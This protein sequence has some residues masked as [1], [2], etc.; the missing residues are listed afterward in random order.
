MTCTGDLASA[1]TNDLFTEPFNRSQ[2]VPRVSETADPV[3]ETSRPT[4]G[5]H[6]Q[7]LASQP[8]CVTLQV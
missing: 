1:E 8:G 3:D 6:P 2:A 5:L 7:S 4:A